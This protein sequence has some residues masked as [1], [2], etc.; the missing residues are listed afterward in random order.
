MGIA[1]Y[2]RGT[3]LISRQFS[4]EHHPDSRMVADLEACAD[5]SSSVPF[6]NVLISRGNGGWWAEDPDKRS[7][8]WFPQLR[9]VFKRFRLR[10]LRYDATK[11][12]FLCA[13]N[14]R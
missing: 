8:F 10:V 3:A 9:M 4:A 6:G 1:Q 13:P 14:P 2:N 7:G 12:E 11:F 5:E